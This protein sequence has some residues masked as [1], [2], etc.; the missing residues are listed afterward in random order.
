MRFK[1]KFSFSIEVS[2]GINSHLKL[3]NPLLIQPIVENAVIP[4]MGKVDGQGEILIKID[5][6]KKDL[7]TIQIIDNG[8]GLI[9]DHEKLVGHSSVGLSNTQKRID[10]YSNYR[11]SMEIKNNFDKSGIVSGTIVTIEV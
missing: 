3:I 6:F 10:L 5:A 11:G 7:I 8:P 1:N 4:A 9:E 2:E